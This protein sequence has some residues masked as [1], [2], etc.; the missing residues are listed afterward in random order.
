MESELFGHEKGA[1]TSADAPRVGRFELADRG[2]ILLDE[3]TE[4]ELPLQAKLLRVLQ[5]KSYERVGSSQSRTTNV[6]VIASTN[7][8][9]RQEVT[10]GRFRQDLYYRLAVVLL[11]VPPLR[12]RLSDVPLLVE[13]VASQVGGRLHR[14]PAEFSSAALDLLSHYHWP[15]NVRELENLVTRAS[16]LA[17][18]EA[19]TADDVR[20]WLLEGE[21]GAP[22]KNGSDQ[23]TLSAG[24]KLE[25]M[26]TTTAIGPRLPR[27][28][29][30]ASGR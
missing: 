27:P 23:S 25:D 4:I 13:H 1:F 17:G 28:S 2:T 29:A 5:E 11:E 20:S 30:L 16:V 22:S 9:L 21:N 6:R 24:M 8:D 19:I 3:I 26:I 10:Q 7:R 18:E 14:Q 12:H 15:G